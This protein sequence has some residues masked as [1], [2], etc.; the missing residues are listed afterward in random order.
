M[1]S[2]IHRIRVPLHVVPYG[3]YYAR[4][5]RHA[6]HPVCP[7]YGCIRVQSHLL[8]LVSSDLACSKYLYPPWTV[9]RCCV[10]RTG[11]VAAGSY[12]FR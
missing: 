3:K 11:F 8:D 4:R 7:P 5:L 2:R 1:G 9:G 12:A 6:H 10:P